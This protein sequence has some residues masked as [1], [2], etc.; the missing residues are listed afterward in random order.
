MTTTSQDTARFRKSTHHHG[1]YQEDKSVPM[2]ITVLH[3]IVPLRTLSLSR[4]RKIKALGYRCTG[5]SFYR[6]EES[7]SGM[8]YTYVC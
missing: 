2:M 7:E 4:Y 5:K 6:P 3:S 1:G 8:G